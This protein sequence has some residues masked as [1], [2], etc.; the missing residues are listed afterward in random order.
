MI[1]LVA[2]IH[3]IFVTIF[4]LFER[5]MEASVIGLIFLIFLIKII[6]PLDV[7][8]KP[9]FLKKEVSAKESLYQ[10]VYFS[11]WVL[12]YLALVGLSISASDYF[13]ISSNLRLFQYCIFFLSSIIYA[14]YLILYTKSPGIWVIF[15]IH[16]IIVG[17]FLSLLSIVLVVL[18]KNILWFML[19]NNIFI[20]FWLIA[21]LILD[22][23][24]PYNPYIVALYT[25]LILSFSTGAAFI[26][27]IA[28]FHLHYGFY[29]LFFGVITLAT[30]YIFFPHLLRKSFALSHIPYAVW[31]TRNTLLWL[32]WTLL[33]TLLYFL[34]RWKAEVRDIVIMSLIVLIVFWSW[35]YIH[36]E[37]SPV[38]FAGNMLIL[39][40]L[41]AYVFFYILPPVF[42]LLLLCLFVF[43]GVLLLF[44][45]YFYG[46]NEE[47]M[48][49][50]NVV[51]FICCADFYFIFSGNYSL[52]LISVLFFLQSFL[53]YGV[54]E[55]FQRHSHAK[56]ELL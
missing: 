54:Y 45:R 23:D 1:L 41:Y 55:I 17:I 44:S 3:G 10:S 24:I 37:R 53:W 35:V 38:F 5:Y 14:L 22:K 31:H 12:F 19:L 16:C 43:V 32:S 11:S 26:S 9:Q 50:V 13:D 21:V 2:L 36:T 40:A 39:T 56:N 27:M 51:L 42:W 30:I 47:Q 34:F 46:K 8:K 33:F 49:A 7:L 15:R 25:F 4:F 52:F 18:W 6:P 48:L 29:I 20:L 28:F